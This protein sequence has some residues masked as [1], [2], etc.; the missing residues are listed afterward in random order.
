MFNTNHLEDFSSSQPKAITAFMWIIEN[1][2]EIHCPL[3]HIKKKE[4]RHN[5]TE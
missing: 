5:Q 4:A 1:H 3:V 2:H